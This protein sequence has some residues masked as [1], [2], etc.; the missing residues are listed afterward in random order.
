MFIT[1]SI[2]LS[3][4]TNDYEY[5]MPPEG[6]I[7]VNSNFDDIEYLKK[8]ILEAVSIKKSDFEKYFTQRNKL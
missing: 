8:R 5:I 4:M 7:T 1:I 6:N 3:S 2:I